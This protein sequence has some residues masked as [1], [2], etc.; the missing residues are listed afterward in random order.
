MNYGLPYMG[1]KAKI[2]DKIVGALPPNE[3]FVDL[4]A[5]GCSVTHAAMMSRKWRRFIAND[6]NGD[7]PELFGRAVNGEF[8]D[9]RRWI[10][11]EDFLA[12]KDTDPYVRTVWSFGNGQ[13]TYLYS[14]EIEPWKKALHYARVFGDRSLMRAFG[15]GGDGSRADIG[16]H[17]EE[18]KRL[19]VQWYI[20]TYYD[21]DDYD[22]LTRDLE[23]K[24][25]RNTERMKEYLRNALRLSGLK[26]S[27]VARHLNTQ[28]TR[29][30]FGNS[31]W[32]F[33][34]REA[35]EKM[36]EIMPALDKPYHEVYGLRELLQSLESL[37]SLQSLERL[38]SLE[39]LQ[40][41]QSLE[42][43]ERLQS[44]QSLERLQSLE[45]TTV[46]YDQL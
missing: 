8:G 26:Q 40:R 29:H 6:I 45:I 35:Y 1:S 5:G 25:E 36:Q 46:S 33:P 11:R 17:H 3:V 22:E 15:I 32:E 20:K 43:L 13:K 28:M 14:R 23:E 39:S 16:A 27:D 19:Y 9:E 44:L 30:Y 10:N 12:L 34:T 37:E 18:Y 38:E 4:F 2:A 31:Q 41:L 21:R 24:I 7:I 42:S